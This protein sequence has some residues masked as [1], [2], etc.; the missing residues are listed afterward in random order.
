MET[1]KTLRRSG[2]VALLSLVVVAG[3]LGAALAKQGSHATTPPSM[4]KHKQAYDAILLCKTP[5]Q[6]DQVADVKLVEF[7][8]APE[9]L[10]LVFRCDESY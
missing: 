10:L 3:S 6:E 5:P 8:R 7:E 9:G 1:V 4:L 2:L